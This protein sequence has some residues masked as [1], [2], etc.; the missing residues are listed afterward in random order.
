VAEPVDPTFNGLANSV[1][2]PLA[3]S[4]A[5]DGE[6]CFDARDNDTIGFVFD[7]KR[8][9][10]GYFVATEGIH[11]IGPLEIT[12]VSAPTINAPLFVRF[13]YQQRPDAPATTTVV[14]LP[15]TPGKYDV[16]FGTVVPVSP[17]LSIKLPI[18]QFIWGG[19]CELSNSILSNSPWI[20]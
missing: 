6:Y 2:C 12:T 7:L 11:T 17:N 13:K 20:R 9:R 4:A 1:Y 5:C 3:T 15:F 14:F 10:V 8:L 18:K 19:Q 16:R